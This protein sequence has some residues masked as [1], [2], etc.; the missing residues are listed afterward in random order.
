MDKESVYRQAK[1]ALNP[2][3]KEAV[4]TI[5]GPV[6]VIAGPGTGKTQVL[7]L[8]I[9]HILQVTDTPAS[10]IL[11][12]TFT[13]S[14]V[15]AMRNRLEYYIGVRAFEVRVSTFHSFATEL[16]EKYFEMLDFQTPPKLLDD[17]ESVYLV[18]ELLHMRAWEYLRPRGNVATYFSDIKSLISLLKRER[19][20]PKDL[21][22]EV[23]KDIASM[24]DNPDTISSRGPT[25]G[26][27]KKEVQTK[28]DALSRTREVVQFYELYESIKKER[29]RMDYDDVLTYAVELVETSE[30]V[31]AQLREDFLYVLI[32]E[33][34]D[35]SGIQNTF[36][37]AV[38]E[39]VEKPNMFVVGD[40]RQLIYGFGGASLSYFEEF[41]TAFGRAV[42]ITL[43]ENYRSTAP[44]LALADTLLSSE[45]A[46]GSLHSNSLDVEDIVLA[47][48]FF[49]RDEILAAGMHFKSL[50]QSGIPAPECALLVPKNYQVRNALSILR[51]IGLP[52][53][54]TGGESFFD[55]KEIDIL[56][57]TLSIIANPNDPVTLS[58]SLFDATSGV[59]P[60]EAHTFFRSQKMKSLS[61]KNL[62]EYENN[63]GLFTGENT[64]TKWG[65]RLAQWIEHKEADT[66]T[67][68]IGHL[69]NEL[70]IR[71]ATDHD[72]MVRRSEAVRSLLHLSLAYEET[73]HHATLAEFLE[74]IARLEKYNIHLPLA[75]FGGNRGVTVTTLHGSKGLEFESV[76]IAHMNEETFM[77]GRRGGFALPE[78]LKDSVEEKSILVAKREAYVAIT[79][80]KKYCTISYALQDHKGVELSLARIVAELPPDSFMKKDANETEKELLTIRDDIYTFMEKTSEGSNMEK[81]VQMVKEEYDEKNVSVTLLNNFFECPWKW[82]FRSFLALPE[83][84]SD[85]LVLGSVVHSAI[86]YILNHDGIPS[87]NKLSETIAEAFTR[88]GVADE[89]T[90]S[91][92]TE[93]ALIATTQWIQESYSS[94]SPQRQ[95][96]RS[97]SHYDARF[98]HLSLYGKIDLT[99]RFPDGT[100]AV[101]DFKTGSSKTRGVIEKLDQENRLSIFLRQL[102]MYTFLIQG[103]EKNAEVVSSKLYFLEATQHDKN[104]LYETRI[105]QEHIDLLIRDI[106]DYDRAVRTGEWIHRPCYF[107]PYGS[108][109][110][111]CEHCALAQKIY[112]A[113]NL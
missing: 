46:S 93:D 19:M 53:S 11:C 56:R 61:L 44:I 110:T 24:K 112:Y 68:F 83:T 81:L 103:K 42:L 55:A 84:K 91:K 14:G 33:H 18:D 40:D 102:A 45:L 75:T 101:T 52:V 26:Q 69:G 107:K 23:E 41:K 51:S 31:R 72:T 108:S 104:R 48:Y 43:I 12:L 92:L 49:P 73:N 97:V 74:Y 65:N 47:E 9:A 94:L 66:L 79:R 10:G 76:W 59:S 39:D 50:I 16:V 87:E 82:Y 17:K 64:I 4:E 37:K 6:M 100:I 63:A 57:R 29:S 98:P 85:Y 5:E 109:V 78:S 30:E 28:I 80:A 38:W 20:T 8:R 58:A 111:Q 99:E 67:T 60:L 96:E 89:R 35:S 21:M 34:Q 113:K 105:G 2:A 88:E 13:R 25:K 36:L 3:Q 95:S 7:T 54:S 86:E 27:L 15:R 32:D 70:L 90:L 1:E 77:S 22:R 106:T 62:L 71:S